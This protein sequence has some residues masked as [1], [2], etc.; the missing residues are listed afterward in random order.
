MNNVLSVLTWTDCLVHL[1]D[2][3]VFGS[4]LQEHNQRLD[5]VLGRLEQAGLKLNAKK[6]NFRKNCHIGTC[7]EQRW[8]IH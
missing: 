1:D 2:I 8:D 3:F 7:S 6:C 4:T 5:E